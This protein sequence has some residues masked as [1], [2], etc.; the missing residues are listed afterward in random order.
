M[1][2]DL[3][4][5]F[6]GHRSLSHSILILDLIALP[7]LALTCRNKAINNLTIL[8]VVGVISHLTLD[9]FSDYMPILWPL[10]SESLWIST[11]LD[12]Q[13]GDL[14]ILIASAK[15]LVKPTASLAFQ[16][17]QAS[18]VAA[19]GVGISLF[20]LAPILVS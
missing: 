17:I 10:L 12:V 7:I 19:S 2:L 5:L 4:V 11:S 20:L 13:L 18:V 3:D 16:S 1:T 8:G 6:H 15:L 9:L 14:L